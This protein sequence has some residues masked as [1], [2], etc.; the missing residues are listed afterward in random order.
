MSSVNVESGR[1]AL[2]M[3]RDPEVEVGAS[4]VSDVVGLG[5]V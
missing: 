4:E 2:R 1:Q 3:R 5:L